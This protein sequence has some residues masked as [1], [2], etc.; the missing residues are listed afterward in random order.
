MLFSIENRGNAQPCQLF[1]QSSE[2]ATLAGNTKAFSG[3]AQ[4]VLSLNG[5][6]GKKGK[7]FAKDAQRRRFTIQDNFSLGRVAKVHSFAL[8]VLLLQLF[9]P[10]VPK[11]LCASSPRLMPAAVPLTRVPSASLLETNNFSKCKCGTWSDFRRFPL[12]R[13]STFP[14]QHY[15]SLKPV[16]CVQ[17]KQAK[18]Q[19][20]KAHMR[21]LKRKRELELKELEEGQAC[22]KIERSYASQ[23]NQYFVEKARRDRELAERV[24]KERIEPKFG[25]PLVERKKSS[26]NRV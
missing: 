12:D 19:Q 26:H 17:E 3:Y 6:K 10:L 18:I 13:A 7:K 2:S 16:D 20:E 22:G 1:F 23:L 4:T 5:K 15:V 9:L 24:R 14:E 21:M 25:T 8:F 11:A